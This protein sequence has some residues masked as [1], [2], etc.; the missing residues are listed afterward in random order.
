LTWSQ[1]EELEQ[2]RQNLLLLHNQQSDDMH[3]EP[4]ETAGIYGQVSSRELAIS[5]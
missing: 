1:E 3:P 4:V 2:S 5:R